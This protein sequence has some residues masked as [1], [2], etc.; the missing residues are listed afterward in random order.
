MNDRWGLWDVRFQSPNGHD[1]DQLAAIY[2]GSGGDGGGK[3]GP[4][5]RPGHPS[6]KSGL[7][8]F[9]IEHLGNGRAVLTWITWAP[10]HGP[11]D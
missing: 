1:Y 7:T 5:K 4:C 3:G 9:E 11:T 8:T 10:G 6:C 2:G